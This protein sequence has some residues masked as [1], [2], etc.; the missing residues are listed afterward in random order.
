MRTLSSV[1]LD[2]RPQ[3]DMELSRPKATVICRKAVTHPLSC[4]S[5]RPRIMPSSQSY[6]FTSCISLRM[7]GLACD[8]ASDS[9]FDN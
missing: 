9:G 4:G 1:R 7:S 6:R 3:S 2:L 8:P 5:H